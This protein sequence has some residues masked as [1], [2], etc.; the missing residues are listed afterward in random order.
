MDRRSLLDRHPLAVFTTVAYALSWTCWLAWA[1]LVGRPT[2]RTVAF[3]LGGFGPF[4]AAALLTVLSGASLRAWL[5]R[6]FRARVSPRYY[7]AA[8]G[9][10]VVA[11]GLAGLTH[12]TVL[13]GTLTPESLPSPLE[14]PV[15]L[16]LVLL[17]GGGQE[18]PGWRGYLLPRLQQEYSSLRAA[19]AVG[20]VWAAWHAPLF[21]LPGAIQNDI[22]PWLYLPQVVAM[23]VVLTWLTNVSRGSVLPAMLLHAGGNAV[24]N[25][26][27]VGGAAGAVAT[28]GYAL[29]AA[30][31]VVVAI[32]LT[33]REGE[34]LGA[35]TLETPRGAPGAETS[36]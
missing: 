26:Y 9:L 21:V 10:P 3:V 5:R 30:V 23:S 31:V 36:G 24:V 35:T 2:L 7:A 25:F 15:I 17:F 11:L 8:L 4:I 34:S 6:V 27:P 16:A 33:V 22:A 18:E 12:W 32:G 13:G 19:L 29:L 20:V 1:G 28:T 14:Y